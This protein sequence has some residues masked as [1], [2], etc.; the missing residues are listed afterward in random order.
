MALFPILGHPFF[1]MPFGV[2]DNICAFMANVVM[3]WKT[4]LVCDDSCLGAAY[5][6]CGIFQFFTSVIYYVLIPT[7]NGPSQ[8]FWWI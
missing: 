1:F 3:Q 6:C 8:V 2:A 5:I 4:D 7:R